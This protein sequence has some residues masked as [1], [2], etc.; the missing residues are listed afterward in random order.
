MQDLLEYILKNIL[1]NDDF[2]VLKEE[3]TMGEVLFK[4]R[5][6]EDRKGLIIG[7]KGR[8]IKS[9]RDILNVKAKLENKKA[10]IL[11]ED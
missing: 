6:P 2:D 4:V 11:I 5:I 9:I 8:N 1:G 7:K 3:K 10:F